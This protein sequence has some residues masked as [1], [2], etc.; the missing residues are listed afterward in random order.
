MRCGFL[1]NFRDFE[2]ERRAILPSKEQHVLLCVMDHEEETL[3]LWVTGVSGFRRV[4]M[5]GR[6][7]WGPCKPTSRLVNP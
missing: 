7:R 4:L 6:V 3:T 5:A 1:P 2:L